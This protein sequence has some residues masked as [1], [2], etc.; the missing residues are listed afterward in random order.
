MGSEEKIDYGGNK[1][2]KTEREKRKYGLKYE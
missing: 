2:R 1:E